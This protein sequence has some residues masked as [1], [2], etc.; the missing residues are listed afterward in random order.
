[1]YGFE[2]V[3]EAIDNCT[4]AVL[5]GDQAAFDEM[6]QWVNLKDAEIHAR[7]DDTNANLNSHVNN[8]NNPHATTKAQVGLGLVQNYGLSTQ[9]Q[10]LGTLQ[11]T[12]YVTP[13]AMTYYFQTGNGK[14]IT[15]HLVDTNNPHATTKA[16]VGLSLV[17]NYTISDAA[18]AIAGVSNTLYMTPL[19]VKEAITAQ[20]VTPLNAHIARVDNPHAT[21]KAQV[22]L[23]LVENYAVA[24]TAEAEA[25]TVTTKYMTP[26]LVKSAITVQAVTPLNAHIAR[27]DNPHA[28]TK[29]QVGLGSVENYG[30]ATA[31]E[32][33]AGALN[34][35][36]MTPLRVKD[37]ITAQAVT[38]LNAHTARTDNP[39]SVTK[40]QVG[41][42][43]VE[44]YGIAT[45]A[46]AI[47]GTL[48]NEYMTPLRVKEAITAQ[49]VTPLNSHIAR[50]D[51]PHSVTKAQVGLGNADNTS[52][53]NKPVSTAQQNALNLKVDKVTGYALSKNDFTDALLSKLN[54][55]AA[56]AQVNVPTNLS[57]GADGTHGYVYSS[58]GATAAVLGATTSYAGLISA[59]DKSKLDGIAA[60][61]QVNVPTNLTLGTRTT[62]TVPVLSSTGD[63]VTLPIVTT[64]LAGVMSAADKSKLDGIAAGAQVNVGTNLS[65]QVNTTTGYMLSST[66]GTATV[67]EATTGA[68]GLMT[69]ADKAKLN[70]IAAGAQVNVGTNLSVGQSSVDAAVY[71]STGNGVNLPRA[72]QSGAGIMSAADKAKLDGIAA[73]AQVNVGTNLSS[74]ASTVDVAVYSSTGG[75]T[76]L[77]RAS[78]GQAGIITAGYIQKIDSI[79]AGAQVNVGTNL[80]N[81][82]SGSNVTIYSSTGG[83]TTLPAATTGNAGVMTA[84]QVQQ[85]NAAGS[86]GNIKMFV[87]W[88]GTGSGNSTPSIQKSLNVSSITRVASGRYRINYLNSLSQA[89]YPIFGFARDNDGSGDGNVSQINGDTIPTTSV[90]VTTNVNGNDQR[91]LPYVSV[92]AI[93]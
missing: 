33:I 3:V 81:G 80:S 23:G 65:W 55:I 21:T 53:V 39:H 2:Y 42:S 75:G 52:D 16:Q 37:A 24:T 58:T 71:S 47:A 12:S 49:A 4:R 44:N 46:E 40:A 9:A 48:N 83:G 63:G 45:S 7:I 41:L 28:T 64:A 26:A 90:I 61:A 73:G 19:R 50:T 13:L 1:V 85:L 22:G 6:R 36:Y 51:N 27:V 59:S 15:D 8:V 66:G 10:M 88:L 67:W 69:A 35:E 78:A 84:A 20:A 60:G 30:I 79:Q 43:V 68:A 56:G 14:P 38:P 25:G 87:S 11:A 17:E 91:D 74:G 54:G 72:S 18:T 31:A 57:Y 62:T 77:P 92:M 29:A 89:N 32:A 5:Y 70:G 86:S 93:D 82:A 34:T 76:T